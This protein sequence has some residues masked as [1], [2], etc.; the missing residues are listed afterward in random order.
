MTDDTGSAPSPETDLGEVE[1]M[2][3]RAAQLLKSVEI[4]LDAH[5][6][7]PA[8][9]AAKLGERVAAV[10][11]AVEGTDIDAIRSSMEKLHGA[12][13]VAEG[14][15][16]PEA[17]PPLDPPPPPEPPH[18]PLPPGPPPEDGEPHGF[19]HRAKGFSLW[20]LRRFRDHETA[21]MRARYARYGIH[22]SRVYAGFVLVLPPIVG[23]LNVPEEGKFWFVSLWCTW[24]S[25]AYLWVQ[26]K[27][28]VVQDV[29]RPEHTNEDVINSFLPVAAVIVDIVAYASLRSVGIEL[30]YGLGWLIL[31]TA[32]AV[33]TY[34]L[35]INN[36]IAIKLAAIP[37]LRER[38][39]KG[40]MGPLNIT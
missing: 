34:D 10:R 33:A 7:V 23:W 37:V 22:S 5:K 16:V 1:Q 4:F 29:I 8:A 11:S 18:P 2:R 30:G 28:I 39:E 25:L 15:E 20:S 40:G 12:F 3:G 13:E 27:S 26:A 6:R 17:P 21:E 36:R 9:I 24:S 19:W 38:E 32:V 31:I 35:K 14:S